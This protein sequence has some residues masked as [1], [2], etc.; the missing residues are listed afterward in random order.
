VGR[1]VELAADLESGAP[2]PSGAAGVSVVLGVTEAMAAEEE[3]RVSLA[4]SRPLDKS[5]P[6][7]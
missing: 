5:D 4:P 7:G 3:G 6:A 1:E 2:T